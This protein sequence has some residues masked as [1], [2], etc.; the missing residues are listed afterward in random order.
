MNLLPKHIETI[1][2]RNGRKKEMC[3]VL[4]VQ[5]QVPFTTLYTVL[6][7]VGYLFLINRVT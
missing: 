6:H 1:F 7:C 5:R 4:V 3:F 2:I